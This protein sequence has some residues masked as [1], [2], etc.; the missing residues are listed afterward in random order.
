MGL[1]RRLLRAFT[2]SS[3]PKAV[4]V[5][6]QTTI[7]R[8]YQNRP[9]RVVVHQRTE[10]RVVE[11]TELRGRAWVIDGDTLDIAGTRVRLAGVDAPEI[12]HPYGQSAKWTLVN[13]CKGQEVRA[14][15]DGDLSH[16]RTVATCYLPDGRDLSA[17]MVKAGLAIDWPKFSRGKYATMEVPGIRRK[18][19]RCDARQKGLMP[20]SLPD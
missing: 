16:D 14:V 3:R 13:L 18:L 15:F 6:R 11:V 8:D 12:D 1:L 7:E 5:R 4:F 17:E 2:R 10:I 20:P 9:P 19:W